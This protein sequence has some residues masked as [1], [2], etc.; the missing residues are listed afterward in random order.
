MVPAV[1]CC[2][3]SLIV[4]RLAAVVVLVFAGLMPAAAQDARLPDD[5]AKVASVLKDAG[6][7][8]TWAVD[9]EAAATPANPHVSIMLA[10]AGTVL[11]RHELGSDYEVNDY[12][13]VA[14]QRLSKTRV[15]VEVLFQPGSER[16][17]EQQLIFAVGN[18]TRRTIL[19]HIVGGAV[20]VKDGLV[21]GHSAKTPTLRKCG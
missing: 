5:P 14:A 3:E 21:A 6:L 11:E 18:D 12:R 17:Q 13:V 9:C 10:A 7:F 19:N 1:A 16:E 20:L 8:G 4:M 15:S 2:R